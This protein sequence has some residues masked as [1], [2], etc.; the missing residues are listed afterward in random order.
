MKKYTVK[1]DDFEKTYLS[2]MA[3]GSSYH[4]ERLVS[5]RAS[6]N[7]YKMELDKVKA[8]LEKVKG[9]RFAKIAARHSIY[10]YDD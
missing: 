1:F 7:F 6:T 3:A 9:E 8:E 10:F 4:L 5:E 2:A